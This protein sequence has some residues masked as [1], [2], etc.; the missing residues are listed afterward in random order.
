MN[1]PQSNADV[2]WQDRPCRFAVSQGYYA[3][4]LRVARE[5]GVEIAKYDLDT[6]EEAYRGYYAVYGS[7][8][9][10]LN[11]F[12]DNH[13]G[14]GGAPVGLISHVDLI[15]EFFSLY[16][17]DRSML[18]PKIVIDTLEKFPVDAQGLM[19]SFCR[20]DGQFFTREDNPFS[21]GLYW[22]PGTYWNGGGW[23]KLQYIALAVGKMHGW[24]KAENLMELRLEAELSYDPEIH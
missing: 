20:A 8:G 16:L 11:S 3:L 5:L 12:P 18:T 19:P 14:E 9:A 2:V 7:E 1:N 4:S 15:P 23:L 13:L 21:G 24:T 22:E 10:F 6:A 17:F